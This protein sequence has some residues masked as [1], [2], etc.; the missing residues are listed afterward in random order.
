[1]QMLGSVRYRGYVLLPYTN[2]DRYFNL[3][4]KIGAGVAVND[5]GHRAGYADAVVGGDRFGP[6]LSFF[7]TTGIIQER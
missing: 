2:A 7:C 3:A 5:T 4:Q 6:P 1:M